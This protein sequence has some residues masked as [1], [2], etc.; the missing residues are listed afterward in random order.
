MKIDL[1][2]DEIQILIN[3]LQFEEKHWFSLNSNEFSLL[4]KLK[5]TLGKNDE[6]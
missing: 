5:E 3:F 1:T 6:H 2:E 4:E